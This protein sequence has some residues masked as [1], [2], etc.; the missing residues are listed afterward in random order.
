MGVGE[1]INGQ[2]PLAAIGHAREYARAGRLCGQAG[3][4]LTSSMLYALACEILLKASLIR[5]GLEAPKS[6]RLRPMF[7][8]LPAV[9]RDTIVRDFANGVDRSTIEGEDPVAAFHILLDA[10]SDAFVALR[11]GYEVPPA[12]GQ[13]ED[14]YGVGVLYA[15][16]AA[17][18]KGLFGI[19]WESQL[20]YRK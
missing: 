16:F 8:S 18:L 12:P 17:N 7:D 4:D 9:L 19:Q 13:F 10:V 1:P 3:M 15:V 2:Y 14:H 6:H 11:Y 20:I 5:I